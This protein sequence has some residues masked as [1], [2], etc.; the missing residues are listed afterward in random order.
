MQ[1]WLF[2]RILRGSVHARGELLSS[3]LLYPY[4]ESAMP[5]RGEAIAITVQPV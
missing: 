5:G 1:K 4:G 3:H 2:I